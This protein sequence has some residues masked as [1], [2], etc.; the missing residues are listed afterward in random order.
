MTKRYWILGLCLASLGLLAT[1]CDLYVGDD[2]YYYCD[3]FG[4]YYCDSYGCYE[5]TGNPPG[6]ECNSNDDCA[7]GCYCSASGICEEAG[8]CENGSNVSCP[9]GFVCDDRGSCVP[10]NPPVRGCV[11]DDQCPGETICN[12]DTGLCVEDICVADADCEQGAYCDT[13]SG[14]CVTT[15]TC[16]ANADC[17]EGFECDESRSTCVP[18]DGVCETADDC[19]Q[20]ELCN[21]GTGECYVPTC[22]ALTDET[23]CFERADCAPIYRGNNCKDPSGAQ[24]SAAEANCTCESFTF[25]SCVDGQ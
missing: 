23:I 24:C 9:D 4:C 15:N 3:D 11:R 14:G 25:I 20:D 19:G 17:A 2:D 10:E 1:G 13:V 22:D 12:Q 6:W 18:D 8:F 21:T 7:A 5:D 16:S